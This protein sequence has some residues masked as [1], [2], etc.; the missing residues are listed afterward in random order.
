MGDFKPKPVLLKSLPLE[1]LRGID[2][3]RLVDKATDQFVAVKQL[4]PLFSRERRRYAGVVTDIVFDYFLIKHWERFAAL[5]FNEFKALSYSGLGECIDI[6]PARMQSVVAG[7]IEHDW[8]QE[9]ST[10]EGIGRT[11]DG[12]SKRIRFKNKMAGSIEEVTDHYEQIEEVFLALFS[13]L[14]S[15][16]ENAAIESKS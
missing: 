8:L 1:V 12:V 9:Y 13:H 5:E 16:V 7:M 6:M 3:H 15:E 10:L 11:I 14:I 2:N 4:K